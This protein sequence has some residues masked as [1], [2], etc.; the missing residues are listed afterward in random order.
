[1]DDLSFRLP[2]N[3]LDK[4]DLDFELAYPKVSRFIKLNCTHLWEFIIDEVK[5]K[6]EIIDL[7]H[8][9]DIKVW[10]FQNTKNAYIKHSKQPIRYD[11][12]NINIEDIIEK[13]LKTTFNKDFIDKFSYL[14]DE[15]IIR[16]TS[17]I[18]NRILHK[19]NSISHDYTIIGSRKKH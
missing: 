4:K 16:I 3:I 15:E 17:K 18:I 11:I 5:N 6:Q 9:L 2:I 10:S 14:T 13:K 12:K 8:Y 7:P 19:E 1:M